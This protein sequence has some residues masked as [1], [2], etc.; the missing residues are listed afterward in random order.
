MEAEGPIF[1]S[2]LPGFHNDWDEKEL[3]KGPLIVPK[4]TLSYWDSPERTALSSKHVRG[5]SERVK[6]P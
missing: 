3:P 2:D 5:P 4:R 1:F 6:G